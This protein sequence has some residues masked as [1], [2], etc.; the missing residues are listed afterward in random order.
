MAKGTIEQLR[1]MAA[2]DTNFKLRPE[3]HEF[4]IADD[5]ARWKK[6]RTLCGNGGCPILPQL[7]SG[8][9]KVRFWLRG[10]LVKG[11]TAVPEG[12]VIA[13]GWDDKDKYPNKKH[14][15]HAAIY[16]GQDSKGLQVLDQWQG[17]DVAKRGFQ[18]TLTFG[19]RS[20]DSIVDGG[21]Y[22][23]VV[24]SVRFLTEWDWQSIYL[25]QAYAACAGF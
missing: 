4:Y 16:L 25:Q 7:A 12:T 1:S 9:P 8:A 11:N 13:A 19:E 17:K 22:F 15:N 6:R 18:R 20:G 10:P 3:L 2:T 23:H 24:L 21:D 14:G 5:L